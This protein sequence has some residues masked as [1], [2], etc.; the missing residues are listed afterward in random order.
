MSYDP[1]NHFGYIFGLGLRWSLDLLPQAARV[2][3]AEAQLTE[4]RSLEDLALT[5]ATWEV[6]NAYADA[7]EANGR[8]QTWDRA[9]HVAKQWLASAQAQID[10]GS[11]DERILL[12]PLRSYAAARAQHNTALM[13]LNVAMS[14]LALASGWD[15]AAPSRPVP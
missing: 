7:V 6:E 12:E 9:E 1:Y 3:Q 15:S 5:H 10:L 13:D 2:Q 8:E 14:S 11:S 4:T